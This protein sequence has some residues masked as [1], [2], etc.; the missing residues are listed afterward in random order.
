[1]IVTVG[2]LDTK[3]DKIAYLKQA[4]EEKGDMAFV[5]DCGVIGE[6]CFEAD[7]PREKVAESAGMSLS[8]IR[9]IGSEAE[10]IRLMA[11]GAFKIVKELYANGKLGCLLGI[12][13]TMGTFLFL[14]IAEALPFGVP[15]VIVCTTAFSP[16]L[17]SELVP[18]DLIVI[19]D[20]SVWGLDILSE[21]SL[22]IA[23]AIAC[24]TSKIFRED[25]PIQEL[26]FIGIDTL[27]TS[28]LKYVIWL[29][30]LLEKLGK[31][32]IAFH[33][34][35]GHGWT[36][37][38]FVKNGLIEGVLHLCVLDLIPQN[39]SKLGFLS[40]QKKLE[41]A[42]EQ[43]IPLIVAPGDICEIVWPKP[44]DE[45]PAKFKR[46]KS[47]QHND[48]VLSIERSLREAAQTA[49]LIATKL[50]KGNG[51]RVVVIPK[52]GCSTWD[53]S[54]QLFYNPKRIKVFAEALK[55]KINPD[56]KVIEL[57]CHINDKS[58]AEEVFNLYSSLS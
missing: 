26:R 46:R 34:G 14:S 47:R 16:Y 45:L 11:K 49:E 55:A 42:V 37:E 1:M 38:W 35:G 33:S 3:G 12:G 28:A 27:G 32:V 58:F 8:K 56:V 17:R 36:F 19:P 10:A 31:R 13:G 54:D 20:I 21:R 4:I 44:P 29:K 57:D 51:P 18:V 25:G 52:K 48:L 40:T 50:N 22:N 30:P 9:A 41:A 15:K 24:G 53:L 7:I 5:I 6:P 2:T 43:G 23:A 39:L